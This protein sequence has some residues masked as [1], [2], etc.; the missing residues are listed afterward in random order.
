MASSPKITNGFVESID[1]KAGRF[2]ARLDGDIEA[3]IAISL[4][5]DEDQ[6]VLADGVYLKF[7]AFKDRVEVVLTKEVWTEEE[8]RQ[9]DKE[10]AKL[11]AALHF[12]P[13]S[14]D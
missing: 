2:I 3:D 13:R 9:A 8:L 11:A 5:S 12:V 4:L 7:M 6:A 14:P 1:R 10:A